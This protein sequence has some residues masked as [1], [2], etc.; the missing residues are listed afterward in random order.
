[1]GEPSA[2]EP[3]D[4]LRQRAVIGVI[5]ALPKELVAVK[6]MLDD[7]LEWSA[8]GTGAGRRYLVGSIPARGGGSHVVAVAL[9]TEMGNNSAALRAERLLQHCPAVRHVVMCGIAGGVPR[10]GV[11]E[12]DLRLGDIVVSDRN[13]VVQYD[14]IKQTANGAID[15]R[16]PPRPPSAELL[17]AV[18]YLRAKELEGH[19]PWEGLL[20]RVGHIDD[21]IRPPDGV[22]ARGEPVSLPPDGKRR[23]G[24]P[25]VFHGPIASANRLLKDAAYRDALAERF[26]V[27]GIEMEGSGVADATWSSDRAGYLVVR[28][29]CDYC[30][31]H[32]GDAWQGHAAA[33]AAAY[34]RALLQSMPASSL[35]TPVT[36]TPASAPSGALADVTPETTAAPPP[37]VAH[38]YALLKTSTGLVG[39]RAELT[40]LDGWLDGSG[41][42]APVFVVVALG[43]M[44][45]SA[46]TWHWF[47]GLHEGDGP[48][49]RRAG[50]AGRLWWSFYEP[51]A[52]YEGLV[53]LALAYTT[54]S[55]PEQIDAIPRYERESRLLAVLD[56]RPFL[57]VLDGLERVLTAYD[58][59][60]S[61]H[62]SGDADAEVPAS[63]LRRIRDLRLERF[64]QRATRLRA[65]RVL[66]STRL[67][68]AIL[69][70]PTGLPIPGSHR[71]DLA[72][73]A[74]QDA[75]A[76]WQGLGA[77]GRS[78]PLLRFFRTFDKHP[79]LIQAFAGRVCR[80]RRSPRDFDAW[81]EANPAFDPFSLPLTQVRSHVLSVA[82]DDL[83]DVESRVLTVLAGFRMPVR[84]EVLL[85]LLVGSREDQCSTEAALGSA[86]QELEDRGL[87][88]WD[89]RLGVNRYDLHPVVRG[90]VWSRAGVAQRTRVSAALESHFSAMPTP[91][92]D[93]VFGVEALT[94]AIE[95][96]G[97]LLEQGRYDDA[98]DVFRGRLWIA[99]QYR[100]SKTRTIVDMLEP[101]FDDQLE[102]RVARGRAAALRAMAE[103]LHRGGSPGR[104]VVAYRNELRVV[105][106]PAHQMLADALMLVGSLREAHHSA[107]VALALS[108]EH[109]DRWMEA[110]VFSTMGK[111]EA[112]RGAT[113]EA[114]A[115]FRRSNASFAALGAKY[116]QGG[117]LVIWAQLERWRGN[118]QDSLRL[119][120]QAWALAGEKSFERDFIRAGRV[121]GEAQLALGLISEADETLCSA[122][123]RARACDLVE[124]IIPAL[125]ALSRC[126]RR[127][128]A[129]E[130]ARELVDEV[131]E[132][133]EAGPY[134]LLQVDAHCELA[135]LEL[136]R[137]G[138]SAAV[139]AATRAHRL[140]TCD[141]PPFAYHWG[142]QR[143]QQ[144]L[145]SLGVDPP[146]DP[147]RPDP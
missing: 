34:F 125:L 89:N 68:P 123:A 109:G 91:V 29:I 103:A 76:L 141:G 87:L 83:G 55:S 10:P 86:L 45:K 30:D 78:D 127:G 96:F 75:L 132:L 82:L 122:L 58:H 14:F 6:A 23:P 4:G 8:S 1:M 27:K 143:A 100:L 66:I 111:I 131:W 52:S 112:I 99:L 60:R 145:T 146:L 54:G 51:D 81:Q 128:G 106:Q 94:P 64:I 18:Q 72:G 70:G 40:T 95:L 31:E 22:D 124:E 133:A 7:P 135:E 126:R 104:A 105:H 17:E 33:V 138:R 47:D 57:L 19:R 93:E 42:D 134:P 88:G 50:L 98:F 116:R 53:D 65:S 113:D 147:S 80:D 49:A 25:R 24:M 136:A 84:Y 21:F 117:N 69:E 118:A 26:G 32:K 92:P 114:V 44:G 56:S 97:L 74:D 2:A 15:H 5:T 85:G 11:S 71:M 77:S 73:L 39:R 139:E 16:Q 119:A 48:G 20:A 137:G 67:Y 36:T 142:R 140:A 130:R 59:I 35:G 61:S 13:G 63:R 43:G 108:V 38:P 121:R 62:E 79:L 110:V 101:L 9:L 120:D 41:P 28:G 107:E 144:A 12:H 90:V 37:C 46:L 115:A 102:P 3:A 129:V